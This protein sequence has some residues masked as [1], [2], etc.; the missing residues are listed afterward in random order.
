MIYFGKSRKMKLMEQKASFA[1]LIGGQGAN[2]NERA[3]K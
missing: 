2:S 1:H 3:G